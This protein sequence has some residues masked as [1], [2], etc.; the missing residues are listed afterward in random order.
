[1]CCKQCRVSAS[2]MEYYLEPDNRPYGND[3]WTTP[4]L[5]DV[6]VQY[7]LHDVLRILPAFE[8]FFYAIPAL[9]PIVVHVMQITF[10]K[11]QKCNLKHK[12]S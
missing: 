11:T 8:R 6:S 5:S 4:K 1:M 7:F 9:K 3:G 2:D 10:P 12:T